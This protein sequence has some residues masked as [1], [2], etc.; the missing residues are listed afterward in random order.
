M[1]NN[2]P[3]VEIL[4]LAISRELDAYKLYMKLSQRVADLQMRETFKSF[5]GE[6]LEHKARLELEVM[7][8]GVVVP[9]SKKLAIRKP[10]DKDI[11]PDLDADFK[12]ILLFAMQK[13]RKA[14]RLY[15]E[16]A[17]AAKDKE[18]WEMLLSL[19]ENEAM[20]QA[21]FEVEYNSLMREQT[22]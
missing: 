8:L 19:A 12:S 1:A 3:D 11:E 15:V 20:H 13:E 6:E 7:K 21:R 18:S 5:A 17:T 16:L 2:E 9:P 14:F 10:G 4:E 22:E